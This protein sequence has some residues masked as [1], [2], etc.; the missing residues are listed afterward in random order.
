MA[1]FENQTYTQV[2]NSLFKIMGDMD[3]CEL[4]VVL[5][6]CRH[7]FGFHREEIKISTRQ[8]AEGIGMNTA[9]VQ[10]GADSAVKRGLIEKITDGQKTTV[11]RALVSD[12]ENE[13]EVIQKMTHPD[14]E[15]DTQL[16]VKERLKKDSKESK[17][18]LKNAD[19]AWMLLAGEKI[20][21]EA[22]DEEA[23]IK[24]ALDAFESCLQVPGNWNWYPAKTSEEKVWKVLREF[25]V[26]EYRKDSKCFE[27]YQTWRTQPY[28]RGAMG[29]LAIKRNPENFPA[30]WS[31]FLASNPGKKPPTAD[32]AVD[33]HGA[34][35][36][37]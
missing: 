35:I 22:W 9:S 6:I 19:S 34:P 21:Q 8:L 31:D 10:K 30:S 7:T 26:A 2:P 23:E 18:I 13:S 15:N 33:E 28:A 1:G 11:W 3:E 36:T 16:G 25:V 32:V 14:S 4:K 17:K 24:A 5:Y 12:S 29:N 27:K 37:Y 20:S